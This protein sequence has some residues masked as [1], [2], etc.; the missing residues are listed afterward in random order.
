MPKRILVVDDSRSIRR[1]ICRMI[2]SDHRLSPCLEAENGLEAVQVARFTKPDLVIMDFA[3]PVMNG[4]DAAKRIKEIW[5]D[6]S[7]VL[8]S[9][10]ME[11]L[12]HA[13]MAKFGIAIQIPKERAAIDLIPV[14]CGLLNLPC[15]SGAA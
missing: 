9:L 2:D 14:V 7:I 1:A 11:Q 4:L 6:V 5:P 12:A 3:M 8:V 15:S 13:E 10:H